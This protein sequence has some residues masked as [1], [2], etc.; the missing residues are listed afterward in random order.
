[1]DQTRLGLQTIR[2]GYL[3]PNSLQMSQPNMNK[4]ARQWNYYCYYLPVPV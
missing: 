4:L 1:V 2:Y 3:W